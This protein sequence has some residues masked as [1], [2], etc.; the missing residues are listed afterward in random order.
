MKRT[1]LALAVV[2]CLCA[3]RHA[4]AELGEQ[5][6]SA[7]FSVADGAAGESTVELNG[8]TL[9][10]ETWTVAADLATVRERFRSSCAASAPQLTAALVHARAAYRGV[11]SETLA[12]HTSAVCLGQPEDASWHTLTQHPADYLRALAALRFMTARRTERG[13]SYV[14][15]VHAAGPLQWWQ[16]FPSHG[17]AP[18]QD[19]PQ[20]PRPQAA[21]RVLTAHVRGSAHGTV[22]YGVTGTPERAFADY[23][24]EL[25]RAGLQLRTLAP[26]LAAFERDQDQYIVH[27]FRTDAGAVISITRLGAHT[28]L[29]HDN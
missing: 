13:E 11:L 4:Q 24:V 10:L 20:L 26:D 2:T 8:Q 14:V 3:V 19:F 6:H 25:E 29:R 17:D 7:L 18:G 28:E 21:R 27:G 23:R 15:L 22:A 12:E 16:M 1:A 5:L 9:L